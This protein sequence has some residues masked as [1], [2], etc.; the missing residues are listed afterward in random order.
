ML[1]TIFLATPILACQAFAQSVP[2]VVNCAGGASLQT[3]V[4]VAR[5]GDT[6]LLRGA[7]SGPVNITTDGLKLLG[8][9]TA[10][11]TGGSNVVTVT[12]AQQILFSGVT[13]SGGTT[14]G[15]VGQAGAQ[16]TLQNVT[17]SSNGVMGIQLLAN[18]A[19][20]VTGGAV[21]GNVV[22]G[23]DVEATSSLTVTGSYSVSGNQVFG[24]NINGNSSLTL[25]NAKLTIS[26][27]T[28][29][30]QLGTT[31]SGFI[32]DNLSS[33][34]ISNN[35][36]DGL[37]IVS[38]SHMVDFGGV[39]SSTGNG[40][41]GISINSKAGLDLDAGSQVTVS[42]NAG[43]GIHME[44][45]SVM[46]IFNNPNFSGQAAATTVIAQNNQGNGMNLETAPT[47]WSATSRSSPSTATSWREL[48]STM[49]VISRSPRRFR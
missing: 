33:L 5:P 22:N 27:N 7:C 3:A 14:N 44:N 40:I 32:A 18:S 8:S 39:I 21:S 42:G 15:L 26:Q 13:I 11:I 36:T 38:G 17:V 2:I 30:I 34:T 10:S 19:A 41:H 29:G 47:C 1:K 9:G 16:I 4:N 12:G 46:T 35:V 20:V 28:L 45:T 24:M 23:I 37:T 48:R 43:D 31:A 49:A 25:T 6:L